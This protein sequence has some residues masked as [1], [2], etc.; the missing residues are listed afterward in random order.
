M[1]D[2][3]K[4]RLNASKNFICHKIKIVT[5]ILNI[6]K[7]NKEVAGI[8]STKEMGTESVF[9]EMKKIVSFP[10]KLAQR[11]FRSEAKHIFGYHK[12]KLFPDRQ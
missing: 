1:D 7:Q 12:R 2:I 11:R 8:I 4:I 9:L 6:L 5:D 3:V 10:N